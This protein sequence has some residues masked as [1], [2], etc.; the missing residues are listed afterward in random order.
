[1][2]AEEKCASEAE[3]EDEDLRI[4]ERQTTLDLLHKMETDSVEQG[5]NGVF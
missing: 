1:M 2:Y 5:E 3:V 4:P